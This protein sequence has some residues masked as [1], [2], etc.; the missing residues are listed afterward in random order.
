MIARAPLGMVSTMP[1]SPPPRAPSPP[2]I[3]DDPPPTGLRA[4][5]AAVAP[6]PQ[7]PAVRF[8][9]APCAPW[10]SRTEGRRP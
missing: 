7:H 9:L 10:G 6:A 5:L 4:R 1:T 8:W 2:G 3:T